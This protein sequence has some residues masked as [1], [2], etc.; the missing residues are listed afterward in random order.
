MSRSTCMGDHQLARIHIFGA[1]GSG[2][3]TLGGA[4]A[5]ALGCPHFDSDNY[6]WL[7]TDPPFQ[8]S[9][10]RESRCGLL[11]KDLTGHDA[12]VLSGSLCRWGDV[13]IPLFDLAVYLSI[14]QDVRMARLEAREIERYGEEIAR[15]DGVWSDS[16]REF[17]DAAMRYEDGSL[18]YRSRALHEA[19][20]ANLPCRILRIEGDTSTGERVARVIRE[21]GQ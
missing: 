6:Y 7:P 19:W 16:S 12:W 17:L 15:P 18:V 4:L 14:P 2:T 3:T 20:M 5:S 13:A 1:S 10:D 11:L 21:I 8:E 9:R